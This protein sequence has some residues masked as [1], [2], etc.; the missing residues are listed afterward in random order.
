MRNEFSGALNFRRHNSRAVK[1]YVQY[2]VHEANFV[3]DH[4]ILQLFTPQINLINFHLVTS[5]PSVIHIGNNAGIKTRIEHNVQVIAQAAR[6]NVTF[7]WW[8]E[9][10][11]TQE[12]SRAANGDDINLDALMADALDNE[13]WACGQVVAEIFKVHAAAVSVKKFDPELA[14]ELA[15]YLAR[16]GFP[17]FIC[18]ADVLFLSPRPL[19]AIL[20]WEHSHVCHSV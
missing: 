16:L 3:F 11:A 13:L 1:F 14:K 12:L 2:L 19:W 15:T 20:G 9:Q 7:T 4:V 10:Y 6:L 8:F 18:S 17:E 5:H